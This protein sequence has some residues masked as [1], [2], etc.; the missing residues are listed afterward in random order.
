MRAS[1]KINNRKNVNKRENIL[2]NN[3]KTTQTP[4]RDVEGNLLFL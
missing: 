4:T 1:E 2:R 3:K